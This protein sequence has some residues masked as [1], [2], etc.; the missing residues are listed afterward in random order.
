MFEKLVKSYILKEAPA[1]VIPRCMPVSEAKAK[2]GYETVY[3]LASNENPFG[4]SPLAQEAMRAAAATCYRYS[5]GS[6]EK[7]LVS[8]LAARNGV[9]TEQIYISG[10]AANVLK[11]LAAVFIQP[12]DAC[13]VSAPSYAPY[14]FWIFKNGGTIVDIPC[15]K[16]DQTMD[17]EGML[18]AVTDR[19]K[20]L[21]ICNPNNP[22]STALPREKMVDFLR[23]LPKD[24]IFV[25]DEAYI[26]FT[27]D[28]DGMTLAP[29][30]AEFPNLVV[31]RTFSKIYGMASARLGYAI[32][33]PEIIA[34]LGKSMDARNVN[35]FG[36]EG[37]IA[38]LDDEE[39]RQ[40]TIANNKAERAYLTQAISNM[41]YKVYD[42]QANFI[43]VDFGRPAAEV[44]DD[45]LPY[46]VIIRGDFLFARISIGLH[47]ENETLVKAL[48]AIQ[49]KA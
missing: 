12:G 47:I 10:G 44:H 9:S 41:G 7:L 27:D 1:T 5:D 21:F 8:K 36:I 6:R 38:A 15:H 17:I 28:P 19:T 13:I 18:A 23:R 14:Y 32:A 35:C 49:A 4:P 11:D 39:F 31:V 30:L 24:V 42:S 2:F 16:E 37:G 20:F 25:A 43:W 22:T 29:F 34:Y 26:D 45:L 3:K 48:Q 46:G 33:C 40:K